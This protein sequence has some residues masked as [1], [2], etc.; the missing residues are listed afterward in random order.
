MKSYA[1]ARPPAKKLAEGE[2][3]SQRILLYE[4]QDL[5]LKRELE[6][7]LTKDFFV[8]IYEMYTTEY[9]TTDARE[10]LLKQLIAYIKFNVSLVSPNEKNETPYTLE[11]FP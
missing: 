11:N 3:P 5:L 1:S 8:F 9:W 2:S 6:A 4:V 7:V 10:L